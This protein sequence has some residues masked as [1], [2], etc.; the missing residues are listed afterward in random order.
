MSRGG[1]GG[2]RGGF[3]GGGGANRSG[4]QQFMSFDLI[5]DV[6][7]NGLFNVQTDLFPKMD[8]PIPRKPSSN[9]QTQWNLRKDYLERIKNSPFYL[10]VPPPPKD[11]ERYSDRYKQTDQNKRKLRDIQTDL[12]MFPEELQSILDPSK[13][14]KSMSNV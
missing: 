12:D 5:K 9:E 8:V 7:A 11:I 10:T 14:K 4:A 1:F 6:G 2:G 3:G 13:A